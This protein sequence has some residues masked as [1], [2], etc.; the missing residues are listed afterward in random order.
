MLSFLSLAVARKKQRLRIC[1][2]WEQV[3]NA[4]DHEAIKSGAQ[5]LKKLCRMKTN[6]SW[7]EW[8]LTMESQKSTSLQVTTPFH[9]VCPGAAGPCE[10]HATL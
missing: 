5:A 3:A 8:R 10:D 4:R 2:F 9:S 1:W 6:L 7:K